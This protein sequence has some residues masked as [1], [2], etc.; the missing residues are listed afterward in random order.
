MLY[1]FLW[2]VDS[3]SKVQQESWDLLKWLNTAQDGKPLSCTGDMLNKLGAFSG[4]LA[5]LAA[6]DVKDNFSKPFVEAISSGAAKSQPN[7]WQ[8]DENERTLRGY[9]EQVWA[10]T[11]SAQDAMAAADAEVT[12]VLAEQP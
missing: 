9:I 1:S 2:A 6:M 11:M 7:I 3:T 12:A 8:A 5:D 10:G 4:N